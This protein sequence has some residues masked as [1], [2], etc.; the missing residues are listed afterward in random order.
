MEATPEQIAKNALM[1]HTVLG[2]LKGIECTLNDAV[3]ALLT[4]ATALIEQGYPA[5]QRLQALSQFL[6]TT[7]EDWRTPQGAPV[8]VTIQ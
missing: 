1:T 7:I 5:E 3:C 6:A 2:S 8:N 4:A